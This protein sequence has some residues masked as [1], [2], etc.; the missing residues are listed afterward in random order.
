MKFSFSINLGIQ[1]NYHCTKGVSDKWLT[2]YY[3][4]RGLGA[5]Q[6]I[7]EY[8]SVYQDE[9][10]IKCE[11]DD[12]DAY[13]WQT[14]GNRGC[15]CYGKLAAGTIKIDS[16]YKWLFCKKSGKLIRTGYNHR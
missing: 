4:P 12:A 14:I 16:I 3:N 6:V 11:N 9:C 15:R 7:S 2:E 5:E 13:N 8:S 10:R 1:E